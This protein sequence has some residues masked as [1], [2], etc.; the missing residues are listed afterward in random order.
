MNVK[1][2]KEILNKFPEDTKIFL[3]AYSGLMFGPKFVH[4]IEL[5]DFRIEEVVTEPCFENQLLLYPIY[6]SYFPE[7]KNSGRKMSLI[8]GKK[9]NW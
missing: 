8:F 4:E 7:F 6:N 1:E 5:D 9:E 3:P 2:F